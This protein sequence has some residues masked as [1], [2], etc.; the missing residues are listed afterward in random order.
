MIFLRGDS[1]VSESGEV[2]VRSNGLSEFGFQVVYEMNRL[3]M[4][5]D[6]THTSKDTM[7][8]VIDASIAPVIFSHSASRSLCSLPK[9]VP[10]EILAQLVKYLIERTSSSIS[11][12]KIN[13]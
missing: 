4:M 1:A 6:I 2:P 8:D 10:D 9:N 13:L 11:S 3:G 7:Q 5:V 12:S